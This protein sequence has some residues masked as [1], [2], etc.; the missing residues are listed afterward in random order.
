VIRRD[1]ACGYD[2]F[3]KRIARAINEEDIKRQL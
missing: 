2:L 3:E 1:T